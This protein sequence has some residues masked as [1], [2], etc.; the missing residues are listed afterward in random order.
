MRHKKFA[1]L[2]T[3]DKSNRL[4]QST[5]G[6]LQFDENKHEIWFEANSL[7]KCKLE[8]LRNLYFNETGKGTTFRPHL[9]EFT[10]SKRPNQFRVLNP[11][12][13]N[14]TFKHLK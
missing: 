14:E 3:K 6:N 2:V 7:I 5:K 13:I 10:G 9:I 12:I 1:L 4:L 11:D 8:W